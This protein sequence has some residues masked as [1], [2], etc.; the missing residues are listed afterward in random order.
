MRY[1]GLEVKF[2][3]SYLGAYF[4]SNPKN[5]SFDIPLVEQYEAHV[6][7]GLVMDCSTIRTTE[8]SDRVESSHRLPEAYSRTLL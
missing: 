3:F 8:C 1:P 5:A 6:A 7:R 4:L 2:I